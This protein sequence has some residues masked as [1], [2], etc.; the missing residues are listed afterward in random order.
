MEDCP[1][2]HLGDNL[3]GEKLVDLNFQEWDDSFN[4]IQLVVLRRLCSNH[5]PIALQCGI[6]GHNKSDFKF[7]NWWL[8]TKGFVETLENGG[9]LLYSLTLKGKLKEWSRTNLGN[10]GLQ[11]VQ[12]LSQLAMLDAVMENRVLTEEE[13]AMKASL[14]MDYE[15]HL[16]RDSMNTK[17]KSFVA[18][19]GGQKYEVFSQSGQCTQKMQ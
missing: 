2:L 1:S 19:S 9:S 15:Q 18:E 12:I 4:R 17:I 7:D 13:S 14:I 6:W 3:E 5:S 8:N 11:R 10:L 16:R